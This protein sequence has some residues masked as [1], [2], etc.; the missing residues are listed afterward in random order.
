MT[1]RGID[2]S[3]WQGAIDWGKV[4]Q[5]ANDLKFAIVKIGGADAGLYTDAFGADNLKKAVQAGLET[6]AYWFFNRIQP[7]DAQAQRIDS[8]LLFANVP[9]E[10]GLWID[11]EGDISLADVKAAYTLIMALR[12]RGYRPGI[13]TRANIWNAA[14]AADPTLP[15]PDSLDIPLWVA[16]YKP[17]DVAGPIVP[18]GW[19]RW[20]G[21]QFSAKGVVPGISGDV[22]MDLWDAEPATM[23]PE[24]ER[25]APRIDYARVVHVAPEG[26]TLAAF[27]KITEVAYKSD[28]QTVGFSYDD[29]GVGDLS[30]RKAILWDIPANKRATFTD[31]YMRWYPG[32]VVEFRNTAPEVIIPPPPPVPTRK[33]Y[34]IGV[35]VIGNMRA[36][37]TALAAGAGVIFG[38]HD[39]LKMHQLALANPTKIFIYRAWADYGNNKPSPADVLGHLQVG[40]DNPPNLWYVGTNENDHFGDDP[41]ALRGRARW[42]G[43]LF[44]RL[45]DI[46]SDIRYFGLSLGHGCPAGLEDPNGPVTAALMDYAPLWNEGMGIDLHNYTKGKRFADDPPGDALIIDPI[47]FEDRGQWWFRNGILDPRKGGGFI[48]GE[49]GVEAGHG[50][51][52]WAG[53]S[54]SQFARHIRTLRGFGRAPI[55]VES[56]PYKGTWPSV[57]LVGAIFQMGDTNTGPGGWAGHNVEG[58]LPELRAFWAEG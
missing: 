26:A 8:L 40:R 58:F 50:G 51:Y 14:I 18:N 15:T 43:E 29:A 31:F 24:T 55:V 13:Y 33:P 44:H 41:D 57:D 12:V 21:W 10:R 23:P 34:Q 11:V 27:Q 19:A 5:P 46:R 49:T 36:A 17:P 2:V 3:H 38:M 54:G 39:H 37:E 48:H 1:L 52:N 4:A 6:G 32:V 53:Y 25:G 45:K 22:D 47:W 56:G 42:D 7:L 35:H 30:S 20:T 28:R 16:H 9:L